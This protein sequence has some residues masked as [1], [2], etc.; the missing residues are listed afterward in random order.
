MNPVIVV[1]EP[2][3]R[4]ASPAAPRCM[5]HEREPGEVL[6]N[7]LMDLSPDRWN[8]AHVEVY[9]DTYTEDGKVELP[10]VVDVELEADDRYIIIVLPG[11]FAPLVAIGFSSFTSFAISAAIGFGFTLLAN[12]LKP[13][14]WVGAGSAARTRP[15][16]LNSLDPPRNQPRLGSRI[17]SIYGTVRTWPDLIF[18]PYELWDGRIQQLYSMYCVTEGPSNVG[19]FYVGDTLMSEISGSQAIVLQ[20]GQAIPA[21]FNLVRPSSTFQNVPLEMAQDSTNS[22]IGGNEGWN[23]GIPSAGWTNWTRLPDGNASQILCQFLLPH[24]SLASEFKYGTSG[25]YWHE[26]SIQ[27][28]PVDP[29]TGEPFAAYSDI[30]GVGLRSTSPHR[31]THR[32]F[33]PIAGLY[34]IRFRRKDNQLG[35]DKGG[36]DIDQYHRGVTLETVSS[37]TVLQGSQRVNDTTR[38][39]LKFVNTSSGAQA[40]VNA[41]SRFNVV[42]QR[43]L[44]RVELSTG[45]ILSV[46]GTN[47]WIDAMYH[48]LTDPLIGD[49]PHNEI[50]IPSLIKVQKTMSS[51]VLAG[52]ATVAGEFNALYD[53][54]MSVD[55]Q[56]R[57][58]A[59][60]AR[61]VL[62]S[63]GSNVIAAVDA[64]NRYDEDGNSKPE[65]ERFSA[66]FNRRNRTDNDLSAGIMMR[67]ALPTEPDGVEIKW[68]DRDSNWQTR[69]FVYTPS[70]S[71]TALRPIRVEAVGLTSWAQAYRHALYLFHRSLYRRKST[72]LS[73]FEEARLLRIYDSVAVVQPWHEVS[74]DGQIID[75]AEDTPG[76]VYV[77]LDKDVSGVIA[78]QDTIRIRSTDGRATE[79]FDIVE[80]TPATSTLR[81]GVRGG[82]VPH[83]DIMDGIPDTQIGNLFSISTDANHEKDTWIILGS[84]AQTYEGTVSLVNSDNRVFAGDTVP[85]P[86]FEQVPFTPPRAP[87]TVQSE[88]LAFWYHP[89]D[90]REFWARETRA[91]SAFELGFTTSGVGGNLL[92]PEGLRMRPNT[93]DRDILQHNTVA[94]PDTFRWWNPTGSSNP[95]STPGS[96]IWYWD[97]VIESDAVSQTS[98]KFMWY[99]RQSNN[100]YLSLVLGTDGGGGSVLRFQISNNGSTSQFSTGVQISE[101][102]HRI[103]VGW[104]KNDD[105]VYTYVGVG[106][107][108]TPVGATFGV[109]NPPALATTLNHNIL[110]FSGPLFANAYVGTMYLREMRFYNCVPSEQFVSDLAAGLINESTDF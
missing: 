97:V 26:V 31:Y 92:D 14:P 102:R 38:I 76:F 98:A 20:P 93:S 86:G 59:D 87:M 24:G 8:G 75:Y 69:Q 43:R 61:A 4:S 56:V 36:V 68:I 17:P 29:V 94:H 48:M 100:D 110:S 80:V 51:R 9:R 53:R 57:S 54:V 109:F 1:Y 12:A 67:A 47:R 78:F 82:T 90:D 89:Y 40:A 73:C 74:L 77:T 3:N 72:S 46:D 49:Y 99:F 52:E 18:P 96:G 37:L 44:K 103:A 23:P 33:L 25:T 19:E 106:E 13:T 55:E 85:L 58:G 65:Y 63:D 62:F 50:D 10:D 84:N 81:L 41:H 2:M 32:I 39:M 22:S 95:G 64:D 6:S 101:D 107:T 5:T 70:G 71:S 88:C 91:Q 83:I 27:Y 79:I 42:A 28:R 108:P 30:W 15:S 105:F 104:S 11:A 34:D 7:V 16:A 45:S 21:E 66:L 35:R 60:A